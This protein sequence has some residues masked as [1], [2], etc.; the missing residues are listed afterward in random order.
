MTI[1][2]V[3]WPKIIGTFVIALGIALSLKATEFTDGMMMR[4]PFDG[5]SIWAVV[6]GLSA[7]IASVAVGLGAYS[8]REWARRTLIVITALSL[9]LCVVYAY[10]G[11][12]RSITAL[13][14]LDPREVL[15]ARL[16]FVGEALR[17]VSPPA[18]FLLVL[19]HPDVARSFQLQ[20]RKPS[21]QA[22]QR[23]APRSDA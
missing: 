23:T 2:A 3:S 15:W 11:I 17:A 10:F 1:R 14:R 19:L 20:H 6:V 4:N 5:P 21:N 16:L 22:M 7:A 9:V 8:A 12:T 13:G 18:F